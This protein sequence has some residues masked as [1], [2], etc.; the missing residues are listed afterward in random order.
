MT[1]DTLL[2]LTLVFAASG[3][4]AGF[5]A[6]LVV[7]RL[8]PARKRLEALAVA[9]QA[10][11]IRAEVRLADID[12]E[13]VRKLS[14][15][16]PKSPKD[17]G[18]LRRRL[19]RAGYQSVAA[20][21]VYS[22]SEMALPIVV[23]LTVVLYAGVR[24]VAL[25]FAGIAALVAYMVPG[26]VLQ[27]QIAVRQKEIQHGLPDAVD[28]LIV[29]IEAGSSLDQSVVKASEELA[30]SYPALA[31]ELRYVTTEIRAGKP[32][33]EAF[34]NFAERTKVDEVRALVA[35]MV[36]TD[37]FGTSIAQA[38]RTFADSARTKRRQTAEEKAAKLGIKLLFPL[39]FC[40]FPAIYIV[41][42][43]PAAI[44]I[45]RVFLQHGQP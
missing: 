43:G 12:A 9:P 35:M 34:R 13:Q 10:S 1:N 15:V 19:A 3:L 18:R 33:M 39:I 36:Q 20:A 28:L 37:R 6:W 41:I 26:L 45:L 25:F 8:A 38:L 30:I 21:A 29:C 17:I 7:G 4:V 31:E 40:L 23:T 42:L 27:H 14:R 24:P 32:R 11:V 16:V 5:A 44:R 2:A 22:F